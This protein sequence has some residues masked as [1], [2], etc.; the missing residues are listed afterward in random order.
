[1]EACSDVER[2]ALEAEAQRLAPL[3]GCETAAVDWG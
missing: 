1:V 3:R 2:D